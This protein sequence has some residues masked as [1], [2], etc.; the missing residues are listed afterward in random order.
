MFNILVLLAQDPKGAEAPLIYNMLLPLGLL[1]LVYLFFFRPMRRQEQERNALLSSL[2]KNDKVI[3]TSG[4]YGTVIAISEKED[5]ITVKVDDN[6]RLRMIKS[7]IA[8]NLSNEE[9]L[10]AQKAA[11]D[12]GKTS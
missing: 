9:A 7:S 2:K 1:L 11:K 5:E 12:G 4:I 3:T 6:T 10:K 8:R